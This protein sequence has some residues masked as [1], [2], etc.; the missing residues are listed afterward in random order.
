MVHSKRLSTLLLI[1]ALLL[2]A[3][4]PIR[5]EAPTEQTPTAKLDEATITA[6]EALVTKTM[7]EVGIPGLALGIVMDGKI[8]YTKGFGV[9]RV[10]SDKPVTPHTI[11]AAGSIGNRACELREDRGGFGQGLFPRGTRVCG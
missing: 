3:C 8:A 4:Q 5:P 1:V 11:F 10:G 6:I 7:S 9:E 2:S